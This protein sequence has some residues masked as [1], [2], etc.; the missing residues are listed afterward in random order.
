METIVSTFL[1]NRKNDL[2]GCG[3]EN[4]FWLFED[5][6]NILETIFAIFSSNCLLV[7]LVLPQEIFHQ[8]MKHHRLYKNHNYEIITLNL[9]LEKIAT[10]KT[11]LKLNI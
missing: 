1:S 2:L 3:L 6:K 5:I 11:I 4:V 9:V 10:G 7:Y 8:T